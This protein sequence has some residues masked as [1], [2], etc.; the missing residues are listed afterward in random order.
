MEKGLLWAA[1][2]IAAL[3]CTSIKEDR[4]R[5]LAEYTIVF[6]GPEQTEG[7]EYSF[8]VSGT[9]LSDGFI[10]E[11]G[12]Q[13]RVYSL[14]RQ[15]LALCASCG[16]KGTGPYRV[17]FGNS[18]DSV[19]TGRSRTFC[20]GES[21]EDRIVLHKDFATLFIAQE[22]AP[23]TKPWEIV[24]EADVCG[25]DPKDGSLQRGAFRFSPVQSPGGSLSTVEVRIPRQSEGFR[26]NFI[27]PGNVRPIKTVDFDAEAAGSIGYSWLREDL[28]DISITADLTAGVVVAEVLKWDDGG[29]SSILL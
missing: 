22:L 10:Y 21:G 2:F 24:V 13:P 23:G 17:R 26:L 8:S 14:P 15:P 27:H 12:E 4:S 5:C 29:G 6:S 9:G 1:A 16:W 18:C 11:G 7:E 3:S 20:K 19:Y 28:E 25:I